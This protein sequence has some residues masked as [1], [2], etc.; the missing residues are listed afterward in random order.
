LRL[1]EVLHSLE[2]APAGVLEGDVLALATELRCLTTAGFIDS[3]IEIGD[4][5]KLIQNVE[6]SLGTA[7]N[8]IQEALPHVAADESERSGTLFSKPCEEAFQRL[9]G[10]TFT[11]PQQ[12]TTAGIDLVDQGEELVPLFVGDLVHP[13]RCNSG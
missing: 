10:M 6:R 1:G 7:T 8:H 11:N 3:L 2:Q 9:L 5:V 12:A 13:D 4:D